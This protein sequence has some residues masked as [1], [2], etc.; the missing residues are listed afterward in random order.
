ML[1][2]DNFIQIILGLARLEKVESVVDRIRHGY[3]MRKGCV[4]PVRM[5]HTS[6]RLGRGLH[7]HLHAIPI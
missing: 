7:V 2:H 5:C 4:L 6:Q 1:M 3:R